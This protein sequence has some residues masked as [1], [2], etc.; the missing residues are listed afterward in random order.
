MTEGISE[1]KKNPASCST[2]AWV[3]PSHLMFEACWVLP[4]H[5]FF[6]AI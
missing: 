5:L 6:C 1:W 3:L 2:P 4:A